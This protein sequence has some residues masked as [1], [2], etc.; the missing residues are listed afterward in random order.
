MTEIQHVA[1][2]L[3][4]SWLR[5]VDFT[6]DFHSWHEV[7]T[8][9][10]RLVTREQPFSRWREEDHR[11]VRRRKDRREKGKKKKQRMKKE[12]TKA[13]NFLTELLSRQQAAS[14]GQT[15]KQT[16]RLTRWRERKR[17]SSET[18]EDKGK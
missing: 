12:A 15:Q 14:D 4:L 3:P 16:Y 10:A 7:S 2:S 17:M 6:P 11:T 18:N 1:R 13:S 8:F 9:L 5:I